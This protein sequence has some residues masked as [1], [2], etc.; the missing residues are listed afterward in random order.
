MR[1]LAALRDMSRL[2][3]N[4]EGLLP[5][6]KR[7][8][9]P[10]PLTDAYVSNAPRYLSSVGLIDGP[11]GSFNKLVDGVRERELADLC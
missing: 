1:L 8:K 9:L 5:N 7:D 4:P 3:D 11:D 10:F 2:S 6:A